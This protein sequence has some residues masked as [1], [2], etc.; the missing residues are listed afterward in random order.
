MK[1]LTKSICL[2]ALL[3]IV[4]CA[5]PEQ[6]PN[7]RTNRTSGKITVTEIVRLKENSSGESGYYSEIY[8][9]FH[10]ADTGKT[11]L[12]NECK[13]KRVKLFYDNRDNFHSN[14]IEKWNVKTGNEYPAVRHDLIKEDN[15]PAASYEIFLEPM[16]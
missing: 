5:A 9:D 10:P 6:M 13:D 12:C 15:K 7:E 11:Y 14:W 4:S 2:I 16:E 8:F 3:F 1:T